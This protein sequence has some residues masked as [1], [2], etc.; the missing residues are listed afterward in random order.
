MTSP[1]A[2]ALQAEEAVVPVELTRFASPAAATA[3][4]HFDRTEQR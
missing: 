3:L 2:L 4:S 1:F